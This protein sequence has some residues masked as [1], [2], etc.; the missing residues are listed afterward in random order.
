L[1]EAFKYG[2]PPHGGMA[3]GLDRLVMLMTHSTSIRDVMAFPKV[4]NAS[5]PM[6]GAPDVVFEKQLSELGIEI[7]KINDKSN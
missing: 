6:S 2:T 4:Q 5:E 3:Y 7:K 1:L